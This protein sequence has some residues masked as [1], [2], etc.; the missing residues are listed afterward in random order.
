MIME[1]KL[2]NLHSLSRKTQA[3][4]TTEVKTIA[5]YYPDMIK[6]YEPIVPIKRVLPDWEFDQK[7]NFDMDSFE[8]KTSNETAEERSIRRSQKKV[9]DY[10][11]CNHF[12]FFATITIASDRQNIE[13]SKAKLNTWLKNQRDRNGKFKYVIVSEYHKDGAIHFHGVFS[14]Y[15]GRLRKSK[16]SKTGRY[17]TSNGKDVYE[18]GEY[19]SGFT[20]VQY[21]GDTF[22]DRAKVGAYIS[23]YITKDM[24][25]L[26]GK[27]RYWTSQGLR[28]PIQEDNPAWFQDFKPDYVYE[29]EYG[30]IYTYDN[31]WSKAIPSDVLEQT[32]SYEE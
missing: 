25:S 18:F 5:T 11:L 20:K 8:A 15:N 9:R 22:E 4:I 32:R 16:S 10:I 1:N 14:N 13:R 28:K 17:L 12:D 7:I 23:K 27:K 19:K 29:N 2:P 31:L 6:V 30:K 24:V 21:M 3:E 26:F